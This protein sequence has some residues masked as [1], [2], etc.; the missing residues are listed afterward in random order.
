M[1]Q[2]TKLVDSVKLENNLLEG[3]ISASKITEDITSGIRNAIN[4][5]MKEINQFDWKTLLEETEQDLDVFKLAIVAMGYPPHSAL[6]IPTIRMIANF[7]KEDS[8]YTKTIIDQIMLDYYDQD[9]IN[10]LHSLWEKE[11]V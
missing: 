4:D 11:R 6:D 10:D 7:Y 8:N 5:Y 9:L 1:N 3:I 2:I